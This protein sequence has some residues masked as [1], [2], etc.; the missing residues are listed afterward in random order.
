MFLSVEENCSL[1][2]LWAEAIVTS[3]AKG[4]QLPW[5]TN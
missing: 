2:N 1:G 5:D 4:S 3:V